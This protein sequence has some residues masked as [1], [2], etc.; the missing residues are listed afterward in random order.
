MLPLIPLVAIGTTALFGAGK[1]VKAVL[2]SNEADDLVS[3]ANYDLS[4][5]KNKLE[6]ARKYCSEN[7][8]QLGQKKIYILDT[9]IKDFITSFEK[10]KN[11]DFQNT[12]GIDELNNFKIDQSMFKELKEQSILAESMLKGT[13]SGAGAGG[14]VAFGAY[15]A[16]MTFAAASTG[17]AISTLSGAAATN[18]TLAWLGGGTLA[19]GGAG[20][21]GGMM[22]LG[23][24]VAAPAL[25]VLGVIAGA[26]ASKKLDDAKTDYAK[27][28]LQV[29]ELKNM[30]L[31]TKAIGKR[32]NK[33]KMM[34]IRLDSN[35]TPLVYEM[36]KIIKNN[37]V[38]FS[39]FH[40]EQK[41][42]I[43]KAASLVK[44]IKSILD[45]PILDK[46][47]NTT[48]ESERLLETIKI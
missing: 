30:E 14:L 6:K 24:L 5:A 16:T 38:D 18:A 48:K 29:Q 20:V 28:Q 17:T 8:K 43:A 34:L 9:S 4:E 32:A 11:V 31:Q 44:V 42:S 21:A 1:S 12:V 39:Q 7:L 19:A 46:D 33:F 15:S 23:G 45:T 2:D 13:L 10:L 40:Q 36:Q 27:A 25:V 3:S 26:K 41:E 22:M 35:F 37:G 47:G